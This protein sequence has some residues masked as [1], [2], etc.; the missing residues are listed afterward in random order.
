MRIQAIA[1]SLLFACCVAQ[2]GELRL[3][4]C[5]RIGADYRIAPYLRIAKALQ[6]MG[7]KKGV[8]QLAAWAAERTHDDQVIVL[9]RM[10]FEKRENSD[11]EPAALCAELFLGDT[12]YT[13]W[14]LELISLCDGIPILIVQ[15][16]CMSGHSKGSPF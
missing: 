12:S 6:D 5:A 15:G 4:D 16:Y 3:D 14:P 8:A 11:F 13:D 7:E 9:C 1:A 10:L 2:A